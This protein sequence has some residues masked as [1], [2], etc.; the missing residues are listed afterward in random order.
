MAE[1]KTS[2]S[3]NPAV[4]FPKLTEDAVDTFFESLNSPKDLRRDIAFLTTC[5]SDRS[6]GDSQSSGNKYNKDLAFLQHISALLTFSHAGGQE[7]ATY[8]AVTARIEKDR[9]TTVV[10]T[11]NRLSELEEDSQSL[12]PGTPEVVHPPTLLRGEYLL[13]EDPRSEIS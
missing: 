1:S 7:A 2:A 9:I 11:G 13:S 12:S 3:C 8:H 5:L 10:V 4:T 6:G